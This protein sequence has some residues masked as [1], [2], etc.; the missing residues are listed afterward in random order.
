MP[1]NTPVVKARKDNV[2]VDEP[3]TDERIKK[4]VDPLIREICLELIQ[5]F[6]VPK[7]EPVVDEQPEAVE[8]SWR[9]QAKELGVPLSQETGGARKKVDVLADIA[10]KLEVPE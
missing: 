9:E 6:Y 8:K 2:K 10:A 5:E 1:S 3:W 4:V 7:T